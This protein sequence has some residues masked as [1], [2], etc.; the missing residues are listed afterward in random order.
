VDARYFHAF[1]DESSLDGGYF[2]DFGFLRVSAGVS[3]GF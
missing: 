1:V 3:V 2:K